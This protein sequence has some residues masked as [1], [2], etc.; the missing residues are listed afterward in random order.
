[1][2]QFQFEYEN[3]DKFVNSLK[4]INQWK[5]SSVT[6]DVFFQ[7]YSNKLNYSK[8]EIIC[9]AIEKEMPGAH[10]IGSSTNGN[11]FIGEFSKAEIVVVC[12]VFEYFTTKIKILQYPLSDENKQE[13]A[14]SLIKEVNENQ[15]CKCVMTYATIRDM[16][17]SDFCESLDDLPES[18]QLFGGGS[19]NID[20]N[21]DYACVFSSAGKITD[22]AVVF[23]LMGG[24]DFNVTSTFITGWKPLGRK[25]EVTKAEGPLLYELDGRPAYETYYKYLNIKNDEHFFGNT[26][27]FPFLYEYNGI[28]I[29]RAPTAARSDGALVMTADIRENVKARIAYGDP[30]TI[31]SCVD[32]EAV[33]LKEFIPEVISV[34]SCAGRRTYWGDNEIG[35]ETKPF[36]SVAP[37]SGFYTSGEFLRTN[38]KVNQHNVTLVIAAMREGKRNL[39]AMADVSKNNQEFTGRVSMINRLATFIQASTEEL[40]V[41]NEKLLLAAITDGL[42]KV[43]NRKEIQRLINEKAEQINNSEDEHGKISSSLIMLDIDNFK[44]VNDTYGHDKGDEVLIKL[45]ETMND[46]ISKNA[47]DGKIGR[48]GGEE[49]MILLPDTDDD[50]AFQIAELIRVSFSMVSYEGVP[51]Q[52]VSI[53]VTGIVKGEKADRSCNRVDKALYSGKTSGKNKVVKL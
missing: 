3:E 12:T 34:F 32:E 5:K 10:Y 8:I 13:V 19:F 11:I 36:Q 6:S 31:L 47:P 30:W 48:W 40:E 7:I 2:R 28:N 46:V 29:L 14:S 38:G 42:T 16:S 50:R 15:W 53:G 27:E 33:K 9:A 21:S 37:T 24:E 18:V 52:T 45:A 35:K 43:L 1:M 41:A 51:S 17:M 44:A 20:I 26:L 39:D 4:K 22:H 49:F 25:L 23:A